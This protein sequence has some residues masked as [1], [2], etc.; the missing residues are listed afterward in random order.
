MSEHRTVSWFSCGAASAVATK[1][2]LSEGNPIT[3]AYCH[4]DEEHPDNARFLKNCE[5][6]FGQ[7]IVILQNDFY[8][9][10]IYRVFEKNYMRTP[11]GS[12]CTRA[13]KKQVRQKFE[14]LTDRQVFGYTVEEQSRVDRFI[15]ANAQVDVWPI[16]IERGLTKEDC[17]GIL[18]NAGIEIPTMYK[19]GYRN[20]N[21][22]GCVKGGQGYWN[23][24]RRDFPNEFQRMADF[25]VE[26]GYTVLKTPDSQPLYLKDLDKNSGHYPSEM[27]VECGIFCQMA[28]QDIAGVKA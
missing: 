6:W 13:L 4:I 9:G 3:I 26:K 17:L 20:N 18:A 1:L 7:K 10:S 24:I 27:A 21:C 15:D 22:I 11:A 12:P 16:L 2:A 19:L 25:E 28:E 5:E 14:N 23:K 8:E